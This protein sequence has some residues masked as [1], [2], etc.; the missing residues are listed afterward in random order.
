MSFAWADGSGACEYTSRGA[1]A[2]YGK[3]TRDD[4]DGVADGT[5]TPSL[6]AYSLFARAM[7][8]TTVANTVSVES[9][10]VRAYSSV[11]EGGEVGLILVN[12]DTESFDALEVT[13]ATGY[14]VK[15]ANAWLVTASD[16]KADSDAP[17]SEALG[18]VWNAEEDPALPSA[19]KPY[20]V[21]ADADGKVIVSLPA[22]SMVALVMYDHTEDETTDDDYLHPFQDD[23]ITPA[24]DDCTPLN[25]QCGGLNLEGCGQNA[26]CTECCEGICTYGESRTSRHKRRHTCQ[27]ASFSCAL[28]RR[29]AQHCR[30]R[31]LLEVQELNLYVRRR[32]VRLRRGEEPSW[33]T[34]RCHTRPCKG[35]LPLAQVPRP[36][37]SSPPGG[38]GLIWRIVANY[39]PLR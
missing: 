24:D 11:F 17:D 13:V 21:E 7:G 38:R 16:N 34:Y 9:E 20:Y 5:P 12:D 26:T 29:H 27:K 31:V 30:E 22:Y 14:S 19:V 23:A 15:A 33:F 35:A 3:V 32:A 37:I 18:V 36:Y 4:P 8:Q 28:P 39:R 10:H 2:T 1:K 6:Y 25:S